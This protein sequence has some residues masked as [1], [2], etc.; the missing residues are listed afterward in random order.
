MDCVFIPA[1]RFT[2]CFWESIAKKEF[3]GPGRS[4]LWH[5]LLRRTLLQQISKHQ[6]SATATW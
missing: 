6:M 3:F 5:R 1:Q 2:D 4:L